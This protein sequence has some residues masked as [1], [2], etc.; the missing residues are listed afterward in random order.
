MKGAAAWSGRTNVTEKW[1]TVG[2]YKRKPPA[3]EESV[4]ELNGTK[5]IICRLCLQVIVGALF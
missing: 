1:E 4:D 5:K 2:E 3:R